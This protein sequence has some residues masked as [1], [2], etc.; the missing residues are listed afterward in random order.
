[1]KAKKRKYFKITTPD[2]TVH[3]DTGNFQQVC[4]I[5]KLPYHALKQ[6]KAQWKHKGIEY[7]GFKIKEIYK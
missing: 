2:G 1:M 7:K 3:F 4:S 6:G 5:F